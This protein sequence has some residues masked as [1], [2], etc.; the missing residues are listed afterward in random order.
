[1]PDE[2]FACPSGKPDTV[3]SPGWKLAK[4]YMDLVEHGIR[5]SIVLESRTSDAGYLKSRGIRELKHMGR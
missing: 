1:M 4:P 3:N 2:I 5:P